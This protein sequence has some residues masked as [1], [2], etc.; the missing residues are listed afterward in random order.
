[1]GSLIVAIAGIVIGLALQGASATA[2]SREAREFAAE[3]QRRL[4]REEE[5]RKQAQRQSQRETN[6]GTLGRQQ[7]KREGAGIAARQTPGR[8]AQAPT[9]QI[10]APASPMQPQAPAAPMAQAPTGGSQ[11]VGAIAQPVAQA[12]QSG[13]LTGGDIGNIASAAGQVGGAVIAGI[14]DANVAKEQQAEKERLAQLQE[15]MFQEALAK[16]KQ[17][18]NMQALSF[19]DS[20]MVGPSKNARQTSAFN[21]DFASI[22]RSKSYQPQ[23]RAA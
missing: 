9:P 10:K 2:D 1:M 12:P 23:Q 17:D 4:D 8:T 3:E 15:Q 21:Q 18:V 11:G 19:Q 22:L 5:Q 16:R 14:G 13:G 20:A 7:A 6:L